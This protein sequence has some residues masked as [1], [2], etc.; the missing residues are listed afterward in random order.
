MGN[1]WRN[2]DPA[3]KNPSSTKNAKFI[4]FCLIAL[5][6]LLTV[7]HK[8]KINNKDPFDLVAVAKVNKIVALALSAPGIVYSIPSMP[9][10]QL[11]LNKKNNPLTDKAPNRGSE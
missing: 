8:G 10:F 7:I 6:I 2:P 1:A 3:N 9:I 11:S 5:A 4:F